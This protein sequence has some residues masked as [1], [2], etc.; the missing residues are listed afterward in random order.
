LRG[1]IFADSAKI[2]CEIHEN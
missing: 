1:L 2:C